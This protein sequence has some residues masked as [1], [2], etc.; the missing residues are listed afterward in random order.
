MLPSDNDSVSICVNALYPLPVA[1]KCT[2]MSDELPPLV[3]PPPVVSGIGN[4]MGSAPLVRVNVIVQLAPVPDTDTATMP[5]AMS[6]MPCA[7]RC[8]SLAL[9]AVSVSAMACW[10]PATASTSR[11][12]RAV[13]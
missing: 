11:F 10:T 3:P 9:C 5:R 1:C 7:V 8:R 13:S 6:W 2:S 4:V 12:V